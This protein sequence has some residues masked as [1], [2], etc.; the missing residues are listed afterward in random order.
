MINI[1]EVPKAVDQLIGLSERMLEALESLVHLHLQ[2]Q[3]GITQPNPDE[4]M[5][6]VTYAE[7][8][9]SEGRERL[10]GEEQEEP[11]SDWDQRKSSGFCDCTFPGCPGHRKEINPDGEV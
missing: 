8:V 4:W 9:V 7:E 1:N 6:A 10:K 2:E 11:L 3:E 5:K